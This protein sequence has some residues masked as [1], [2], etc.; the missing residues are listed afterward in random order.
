MSEAISLAAV[1]KT[2]P[3]RSVESPSP[4]RARGVRLLDGDGRP[5]LSDVAGPT[6]STEGVLGLR[7]ARGREERPCLEASAGRSVPLSPDGAAGETPP[8]PPGGRFFR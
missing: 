6:P 4:G 1:D 3:R 5:A 8:S 2:H 7:E